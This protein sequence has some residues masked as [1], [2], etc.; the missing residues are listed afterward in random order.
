MCLSPTSRK[1]AGNGANI[2]IFEKRWSGVEGGFLL[3]GGSGKTEG[4]GLSDAAG[5]GDTPSRRE[6]GMSSWRC[7][8]RNVFSSSFNFDIRAG[9][10]SVGLK[11]G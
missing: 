5:S 2:E 7:S 4:G 8:A 11:A 1:Y 3:W 10:V 9:A 6:L